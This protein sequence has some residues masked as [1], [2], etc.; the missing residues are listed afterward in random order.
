[1]LNKKREKRNILDPDPKYN[2]LIGFLPYPYHFLPPSF[3]VIHPVVFGWLSDKQ[4]QKRTS[5]AHVTLHSNYILK[6]RIGAL[7]ERDTKTKH[8]L[9]CNPLQYKYKIQ[10][11][12]VQRL[13]ER[14]PVYDIAAYYGTPWRVCES[15][16]YI[17]NLNFQHN[18]ITVVL[19]GQM[20]NKVPLC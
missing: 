19:N 15:S 12:K 3:V 8:L 9:L 17:S 20:I 5:L 11:T 4:N 18:H 14:F 2:F 1:M 10:W 6:Y 7:Q 13:K 16:L